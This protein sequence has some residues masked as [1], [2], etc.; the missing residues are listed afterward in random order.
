MFQEF[1]GQKPV[2]ISRNHMDRVRPPVERW[3]QPADWSPAW[4]YQRSLMTGIAYGTSASLYFRFHT[5]TQ[6]LLEH[7]QAPNNLKQLG[8]FAREVW[9]ME[10]FMKGLGTKL[11]FF[12]LYGAAFEGS[13]FY[14]WRNFVGGYPHDPYVVDVAWYKKF[15]TALTVGIS[16]MWI[17]VPFVNI[18]VRYEQDKILPKEHAR[19]YRGYLH[20]AY[21]I[22]RKDGAF[23]FIRGGGPIMAEKALQTTGMFFWL[24]FLRDKLKHTEHFGTDHPGFS[25]TYLRFL[26]VS[27]GT[28]IGLLYGYPMVALKNYVEGL[29]LNS[30]GEPYF[31]TYAEAVWKGLGDNFNYNLLWIGFHRYLIKCGPPLFATLWFADRIGLLEQY[32]V[33]AILVPDS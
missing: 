30:K 7:Y 18:A 28:Y 6:E 21:V 27:F 22:A 25:E 19:G 12:S 11:A 33:D 16:T 4:N 32:Q 10:T 3:M 29:P 2:V 15:I 26:Y 9:K 20:A 14:M 17:P 1:E 23:P 24:D 31:A 13:R 5:P 8:I